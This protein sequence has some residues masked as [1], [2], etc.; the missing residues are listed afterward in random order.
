MFKIKRFFRALFTPVT[1][2]MIPHNNKNLYRVKL[3]LVLIMVFLLLWAS[4]TAYIAYTGKTTADY[5]RL[6]QRVDFYSSQLED[7]NETIRSLKKAES[8]FKRLFALN[9]REEILEN[10]DTTYSGSLDIELLKRQIE[11]TMDEVGEIRDYLKKQ[12]DIYYATPKGSPVEEGYIASPY[13]WR[14]HPRTGRRTFHRGV[15]IAAWPGTPVR[16]TADGVVSF[17]GW[18]GG[19]GKLVVIEHGFG[20][21]TCYAHNKKIVVKVGQAVKR[22]QI[23]AYVG[24]TGNTTGPHVHY[25][26]WID[27]KS[28]NPYKY[29]K[30]WINAKKEKQ[31]D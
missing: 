12:H 2:M 21:T 27:R 15:D 14:I 19:S 23:I 25:E 5:K 13:G 4:L 8:D 16:A 11:K 22:G 9:S 31:Q 24:S 30:E 3:P 6:K 1:I 28:V 10:I 26:V 7:I 17:A 18:S 20:F 29:L